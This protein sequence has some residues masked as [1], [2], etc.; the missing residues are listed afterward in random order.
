MGQ[1]KLIFSLFF[2]TLLL[3]SACHP[4]QKKSNG[5]SLEMETHKT[6]TIGN[7]QVNGINISYRRAGNGPPLIFI[8]GGAED[9]RVWTPQLEDLSDEF[10]VIAWD[11]PGAGGSS[12]LPDNFNLED[13]AD[14]FAGLIKQLDL[15]PV[16]LAGFS[17]GSTLALEIY[18]RHPDLIGKLI[19]IGGYAGWKGSLGEEEAQARL[20]GVRKMLS[21]SDNQFDPTLPGLFAGGPPAKFVPLLNA[22][23]VDVRP[24]SMQTAL[25]IMAQTD[26]NPV[27]PTIAVPTLLVWGKLDVRSPLHIAKEFDQKIPNS[28][29]VV[30]PECGHVVNLQA[31]EA[32]NEAIRNFCR[33]N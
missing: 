7:L 25:E 26:L 14:C 4:N 2:P 1:K 27:L 6:I 33:S 32:F 15:E 10:T 11:E 16:H 5:K 21:A 3:G 31:P 13:Y 23:A 9:S 30:I 20:A 29:L 22:M 19:L 8:H 12:D 18:R 24:K 28:R 17:W